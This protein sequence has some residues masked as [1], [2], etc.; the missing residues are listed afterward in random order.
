MHFLAF[1]GAA[2]KYVAICYLSLRLITLSAAD[3]AT[4]RVRCRQPIG[5]ECWQRR[6]ARPEAHARIGGHRCREGPA[7]ARTPVSAGVMRCPPWW[8]SP[9][10]AWSW[11]TAQAF[12][13]TCRVGNSCGFDDIRAFVVLRL[14]SGALRRPLRLNAHQIRIRTRSRCRIRRRRWREYKCECRD[15]GGEHRE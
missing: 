9:R 4:V 14:T 2:G 6:K 5:A 12:T 11:R 8:R 13:S 1:C 7:W 3:T 10:D 15:W